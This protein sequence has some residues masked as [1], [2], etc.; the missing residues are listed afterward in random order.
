M[1]DQP[2]SDGNPD[3]SQLAKVDVARAVDSFYNVYK[4]MCRAYMNHVEINTA[5]VF[6]QLKRS[7][8]VID[9]AQ[10]VIAGKPVNENG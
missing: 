9:S 10:R 8:E 2:E 3:S 1:R 4:G 6:D 7:I 5:D